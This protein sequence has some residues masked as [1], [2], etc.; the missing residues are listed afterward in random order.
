MIL[1]TINLDSCLIGELTGLSTPTTNNF[2]TDPLGSVI[3]PFS[4]TAGSA[5]LSG[6]QA[7]GPCGHLLYNAGGLSGMATS[8][9]FSGQ[10]SDAFSGLD[11]YNARYYEPAVGIFLSADSKEGNTMGM[12]PYMYVGGN[13]ETY[14]DP[15]GQYYAPPPQGN[16]N[17]PPTCAQVYPYC[18]SVPDG[19]GSNPPPTKPTNHG[20]KLSNG[21]DPSVDQSIACKA[22]AWDAS[23]VRSKRLDGLNYQ[24]NLE[25]LIGYGLS[26]VADL[27][28]MWKGLP[29]EKADA[30]LDFITTLFNTVLPLVGTLFHSSSIY[31]A[32]ERISSLA[33]GIES[34]VESVIAVLRGISGLAVI[35]EEATLDLLVASATGP[36]GV[37]LQGLMIFLQP[38]AGLLLDAGAH[39]V[40]SLGYADL[41]EVTRQTA[42]PLQAWCVQYGGCPSYSSYR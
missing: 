22:W 18:K 34:G 42:M 36:A 20:V 12:D 10:Y 21:C 23:N 16:G 38:I 7:Y 30:F 37:F 2:L 33:L 14:N 24:A 28:G 8:K 32:A 15:T 5:A 26:L 25:L 11:Y 31:Q 13:P 27:L 40:E 41:A 9:G 29:L 1:N 39:Y 17:P 3:A 6:N 4:T 35:P 19:N